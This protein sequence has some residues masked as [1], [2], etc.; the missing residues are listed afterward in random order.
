MDQQ[1]AQQQDAAYADSLIERLR[2]LYLSRTS[3]PGEEQPLT[4]ARFYRFYRYLLV[5]GYGQ[6]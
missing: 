6:E 4:M 5:E 1:Q 3:V 2:E